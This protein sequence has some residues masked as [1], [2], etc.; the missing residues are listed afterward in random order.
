ELRPG[1]I[2]PLA[3]VI[4]PIFF[5]EGHTTAETPHNFYLTVFAEFGL[6]GAA[7]FFWLL[8]RLFR[9]LWRARRLPELTLP[10]RRLFTAVLLG[11]CAFLMIGM[12][13]AVLMTS[14]RANL[15][16]WIFAGLALRYARIKETGLTNP[17]SLTSPTKD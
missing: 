7:F 11:L 15:V 9:R 10:E 5:Y 16:F 14:V 1:W 8:W 17:T 4:S 13:E 3:D 6:I 2:P 12:F